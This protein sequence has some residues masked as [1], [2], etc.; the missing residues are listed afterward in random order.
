MPARTVKVQHEE[1][2]V[3]AANGTYSA[4]LHVGSSGYPPRPLTHERAIC[5]GRSGRGF[6]Y[7]IFYR[8]LPSTIG[9]AK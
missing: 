4:A 7:R 9:D 1:S 5:P 3:S 2:A 8:Q 6:F